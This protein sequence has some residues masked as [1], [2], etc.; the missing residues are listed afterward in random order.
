DLLLLCRATR[1]TPKLV[2]VDGADERR[3]A[4]SPQDANPSTRRSATEGVD[5]YGRVEEDRC[6]LTHA[7]RVKPPLRAD[8]LRRG[9]S[10]VAAVIRDRSDGR[11]DVV[12]APLVLERAPDGVGDEGAPLAFPD[13]SVHGLHELRIK[14]YVQTHAHNLAH[15]MCEAHRQIERPTLARR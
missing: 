9:H 8:P 1:A 10:P 12:P 15:S 5:E 7:S 13:A 4:D 11:E 14:A 3:E 6:H 2:D